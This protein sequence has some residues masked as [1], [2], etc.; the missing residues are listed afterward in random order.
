[1]VTASESNTTPFKRSRNDTPCDVYLIQGQDSCASIAKAHSITTADIEK[2]NSKTY[3]WN[4]CDKL[5]QGDFICI[6]SGEPPM[7]AALPNAVCGP[8][9]PGT[10]RQTD[11]E[12]WANLGSLN[13]C[14]AGQCVCFPTL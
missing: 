10:S 5:R 8:Q 12:G 11:P 2:Y 7:P 14:P 1:M 6:S 4:S 13:P 9:V 3:S